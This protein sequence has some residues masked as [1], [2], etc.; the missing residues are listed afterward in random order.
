M[1]KMLRKALDLGFGDLAEEMGLSYDDAVLMKQKAQEAHRLE[2]RRRNKRS[3]KSII[4]K[5]IERFQ[6]PVRGLHAKGVITDAQYQAAASIERAYWLKADESGTFPQYRYKERTDRSKLDDEPIHRI[7]LENR[8]S[9]WVATLES[10]HIN[11]GMILEVIVHGS[12]LRKACRP[13]GLTD[14]G[15]KEKIRDA[16]NWY[17]KVHKQETDHEKAIV[18][19]YA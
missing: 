14:K 9:R 12:S 8:Y 2:E 10:K 3:S 16:L 19:N 17:V 15:A 7:K 5:A 4:R 11:V 18:V 6:C 13:F 1:D